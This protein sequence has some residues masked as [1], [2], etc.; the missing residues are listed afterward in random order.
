M[1]A[2][3]A[4]TMDFNSVLFTVRDA[5]IDYSRTEVTWLESSGQPE[6]TIVANVK[7]GDFLSYRIV[8]YDFLG[9]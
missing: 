4:P 8:F 2:R 7:T 9:R 6:G 1:K 3:Y 5:Q